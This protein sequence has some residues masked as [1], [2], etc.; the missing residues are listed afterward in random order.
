M[1]WNEGDTV[2]VD[3]VALRE[4]RKDNG[5]FDFTFNYPLITAV[6]DNVHK[7]GCVDLT[8]DDDACAA[9]LVIGHVSC[10]RPTVNDK[11]NLSNLLVRKYIE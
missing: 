1:Q 9:K 10:L 3:A 4:W 5:L 8:L 7:D 11:R 6:I 2:T